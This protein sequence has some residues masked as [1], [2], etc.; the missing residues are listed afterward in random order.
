MYVIWFFIY[1]NCI[2]IGGG[3]VVGSILV[4]IV[5]LFFGLIFKKFFDWVSNDVEFVCKVGKYFKF[6]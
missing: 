6:F 3:G 2:V 5:I 1:E 4:L